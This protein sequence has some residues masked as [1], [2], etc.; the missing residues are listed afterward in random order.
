MSYIQAA[1]KS[2]RLLAAVGILALGGCSQ[3][4]GTSVNP[5][6]SVS[7]TDNYAYLEK[8]TAEGRPAATG[9]LLSDGR[10]AWQDGD[11]NEALQKFSRALRISPDD[12]L[13]YY[14]LARIR[15]EEGEYGK[16]ISLARRGLAFAHNPLLREHLDRL[17]AS[18]EQSEWNSTI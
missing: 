11:L 1:G 14:Y 10:I 9:Q 3:F 8:L 2:L 4:G 12:G 18:T 16:A 13:I 5:Y 6:S 7:Q 17:I 15:K